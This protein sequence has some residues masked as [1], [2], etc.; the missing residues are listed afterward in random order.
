[1]RVKCLAQEHNAVSP[2]RAQTP[3]TQSGV[4]DTNHE[5]TLPPTTQGGINIKVIAYVEAKEMH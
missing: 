2:A 3:T 1:M 5:V 4:Q